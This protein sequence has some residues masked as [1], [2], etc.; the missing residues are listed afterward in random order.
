MARSSKWFVHILHIIL[1]LMSSMM[2]F[3]PLYLNKLNSITILGEEN[4]KF[5]YFS[6]SL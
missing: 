4:D 6:F 3:I 2:D 5:K 1:F